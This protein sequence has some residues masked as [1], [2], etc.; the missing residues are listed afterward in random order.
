[1]ASLSMTNAG[2]NFSDVQTVGSE[3]TTA[4]ILDHYEEGTYVPIWVSTGM[5]PTYNAR[6]GGYSKVGR[7]VCLGGY[8]WTTAMSGTQTNPCRHGGLPFTALLAHNS[9]ITVSTTYGS[10]FTSGRSWWAADVVASGVLISIYSLGDS[11]TNLAVTPAEMNGNPVIIQVGGY[12]A[13]T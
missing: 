12:Y 7:I 2:L 8:I 1:M 3:T 9:G 13:S 5:T 6:A 11:T 10:E 4:E